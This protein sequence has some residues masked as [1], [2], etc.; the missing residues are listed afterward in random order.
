[1]AEVVSDALWEQIEPLLP[2]EPE[3]SPLGGRPRVSNRQAFTGVVFV[4]RT[5]IPWQAL[6]TEMGCGSG[7]TCWR[8]FAEWTRL[9]V[10][11]KLHSL[12]LSLLGKAGAVNLER[13]VIDS[14]SVRAVFGGR[15]PARTPRTVRKPAVS[16]TY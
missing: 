3:P 12:L 2:P 13:A 15:T 6:P 16:G 10:W 11:S 9:A 5:G 14:A 8:R 1:M 4:L 7:S